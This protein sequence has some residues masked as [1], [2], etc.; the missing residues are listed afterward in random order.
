MSEAAQRRAYVEER[1]ERPV[2]TGRVEGGVDGGGDA[3]ATGEE[4]V[5]G[6]AVGA[7]QPVRRGGQRGEGRLRRAV[8]GAITELR[9]CPE[10]CLP[11]H[12]L[13]PPGQ[14]AEQLERRRVA[15]GRLRHV[16]RAGQGAAGP[17]APGRELLCPAV[18]VGADRRSAAEVRDGAEGVRCPAPVLLPVGDRVQVGEAVDDQDPVGVDRLQQRL[19][20]VCLPAE[21]HPRRAGVRGMQGRLDGTG[22]VRHRD[23]T[24]AA[25]LV[26]QIHLE[27][28][29]R[30]E[31]FLLVPVE[32]GGHLGE[33]GGAR[34]EPVRPAQPVPGALRN[35][36]GPRIAVRETVRDRAEVAGEHRCHAQLPQP[37][38]DAPAQLRAATDQLGTE[39]AA[40]PAHVLEQPPRLVGRG[41]QPGAGLGVAVAEVLE[42][43]VVDGLLPGGDQHLVAAVQGQDVEHP[44]PARPVGVRGG[45]AV[46]GVVE[47]EPVGDGRG[48]LDGGAGS[49]QPAGQSGA[50]AGPGDHGVAGVLEVPVRPGQGGG[51]CGGG[52]L[53]PPGGA[54]DP[55][56]VLRAVAPGEGAEPELPGV[57][58]Q[59]TAECLVRG[60]EVPGRSGRSSS[61]V[62]GGGGAQRGGGADGSG[63]AQQRTSRQPGGAEGQ[64]GFRHDPHSSVLF[65]VVHATTGACGAHANDGRGG[66]Q[67]G[68]RRFVPIQS[69]GP[70]G[71]AAGRPAQPRS[72]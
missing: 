20:R 40:V 9:V 38:G 6:A 25:A 19:P 60:R 15:L 29:R 61:G 54:G 11:V 10:P 69:F 32:R 27:V 34:V 26:Q 58:R 56:A 33:D 65:M 41:G 52:D 37:V 14:F 39:R 67:W 4:R 42:Q 16:G 24:G 48:A 28:L 45:V 22:G 2:E 49:G 35:D 3:G 68:V 72:R 46:V 23:V 13:G 53:D 50:A 7:R 66:G 57:V 43:P 44:L 12:L 62:R 63:G 55:E 51:R 31:Q 59:Q 8:T 1:R 5:D 71:G 18:G 64:G 70:D 17:V 30:T 47:G 21:D 36:P